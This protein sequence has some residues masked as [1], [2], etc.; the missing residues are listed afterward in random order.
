MLACFEDE[1]AWE[2]VRFIDFEGL[3]GP[4]KIKCVTRHTFRLYLEET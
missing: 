3:P 1:S 2:R 4:I